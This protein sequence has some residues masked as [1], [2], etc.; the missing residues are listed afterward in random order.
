MRSNGAFT[1]TVTETDIEVRKSTKIELYRGV[2][3]ALMLLGAVGIVLVSVSVSV[4]GP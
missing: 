4:N 1:L 2:H 3:A